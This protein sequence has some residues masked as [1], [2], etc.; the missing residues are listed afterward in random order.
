MNATE[1]F[2]ELRAQYP[3]RWHRGQL[4]TFRNRV[5]LW[6]EDARA[7]GVE[8]GR[9]RYRQSSKPR[10]RRRPDPLEANWAEMLQSLE[11]DPDQTSQELLAAFMIRYPGRY[12]V[13]H[14]RTVQ[15]RM[16]IWR[17]DAVQ[18]LII[19]MGGLTEDVSCNSEGY[20]ESN[21]PRE[22]NGKKI[23]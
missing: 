7:R 13:G 19:E 8:I 14:L 1:L 4:M 22:A 18:R 6:R 15:R 10:T 20:R 12:D 23:T 5:R 16:K 11:A 9:L 17:H 3:G 2:D 21:E